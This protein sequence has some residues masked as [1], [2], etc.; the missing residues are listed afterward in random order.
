MNKQAT[1]QIGDI[2]YL[3]DMALDGNYEE[4][5]KVALQIESI[6][7]S[8]DDHPGYDESVGQPLYDVVFA[9]TGEPVHNSFYEYEL[10]A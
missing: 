9:E 4:I 1:F 5:G 2:V 10:E 8:E 3:T 7:F 6:S